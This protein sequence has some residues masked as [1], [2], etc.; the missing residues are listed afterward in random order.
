MR[1]PVIILAVIVGLVAAFV[2]YNYMQQP[3][4]LS[5]RLESGVDQLGAGNLG[6][7]A[8][9]VGNETQGEKITEDVQ[10]VISPTN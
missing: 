3:R 2:G 6:E 8:N 1:T 5:D 10:D 4:P 7:A 9:E